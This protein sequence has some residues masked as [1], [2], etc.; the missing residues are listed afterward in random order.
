MQKDARQEVP[1]SA[2]IQDAV[3]NL[4][5][6]IRVVKLY[7]PNN[8]VY[9]QSVKKSHESLVNFFRTSPDFRLGVQKTCFTYRDTPFNKDSQ[10]NKAII[11]DLFA[12][13]VREIVFNAEV[14]EDELLE[15]YRGLAFSTEELMM[16]NG[17]STVLW[18]KGATHITVIEAGLDDVVPGAEEQ[19]GREAAGE[20][21]S[22]KA[23]PVTGRTLVL[24]DLKTDPESFGASMLE[25][26][27]RTRA[28]HESVEDRLFA[29]YQQASHKISSEHARDSEAL[30][31]GLAKSILSLEPLYRDSLIA[32]RLYRDMDAESG[33]EAE[34]AGQTLPN[35]SQEVMTGR[36]SHDW[37]VEQVSTLLKRSASKKT[38]PAGPPPNP[39]DFP[40][41][42]VAED[43]AEI[44]RGLQ[45]ESPGYA[46]AM[47][48][49]SSAGMESDII[50]AAVRTLTAVMPLVR[51]P[52]RTGSSGDKEV[53]LFS[54]IVLQLE[55][56][57]GYLLKK[58][59]YRVATTIIEALRRPV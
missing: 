33:A 19:D 30:F 42:P 12:K 38:T 14:S 32:G 55:D 17:I 48:T 49:I 50:E 35:L 29:L 15:L 44:A 53:A 26:A 46:E 58:N 3:K 24:G 54:G 40:V 16:K 51:N 13:G 20:K 21:S 36:F 52:Q 27:K 22:K 9:F 37:T 23:P 7:P 2:E 18:E 28:A 45:D 34:F 11:Q 6:A 47:K 31:Q 59:N 41:I 56:L 25:F 57:L 4:A 10:V 43:L 39:A 5:T 1:L 8:P